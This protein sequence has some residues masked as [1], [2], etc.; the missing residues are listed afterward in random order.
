MSFAIRRTWLQ[1]LFLPVIIYVT[2]SELL[3][4]SKPQ[5]PDPL[6]RKSTSTCILCY[7]EVQLRKSKGTNAY[8]VFSILPGTG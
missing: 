1:V 6:N 5:L 3:N 7:C 8:E 4:L 2:I